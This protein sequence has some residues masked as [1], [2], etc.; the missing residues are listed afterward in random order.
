LFLTAPI[1]SAFIEWIADINQK[2]DD[3]SIERLLLR[4][5]YFFGSRKSLFSE[6]PR[7]ARQ[8][9]PLRALLFRD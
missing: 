6:F 3:H 5:C 7:A 2:Q 9:F 4:F 8:S 1:R